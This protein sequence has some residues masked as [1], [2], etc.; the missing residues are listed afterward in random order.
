MLSNRLSGW[1]QEIEEARSRLLEVVESLSAELVKAPVGDGRW[2]P[3]Q[4]LEHLV[5]A[6]E[7]TL[8]RM[9]GAVEG[10][11]QGRPGPRSTTPE[12]TIEEVIE[13]TWPERVEAPPLAVPD[14]AGSVAYW[15]V[16]MR[17]NAEL[18]RE[19]AEFVSESELETVAYDHP[20]SGPFT[21]RQGMEF[22]RFHIDRHLRHVL[23]AVPA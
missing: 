8:W 3:V 6:E 9:F 23:E 14:W 7:A 11:R 5:R 1:V 17:R 12:L 2:S 18:V 16:R 20:I 4:Y 19:F 21:M 22:I 13:R 15:T 10:A